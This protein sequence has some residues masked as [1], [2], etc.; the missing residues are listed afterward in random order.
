[1]GEHI[2][3]TDAFTTS[4]SAGS[5]LN[6][7]VRL[8]SGRARQLIRLH[9]IRHYL[10][11]QPVNQ[12]ED[13]T[14]E[15]VSVFQAGPEEPGSPTVAP[16]MRVISMFDNFT[17][18]QASYRNRSQIVDVFRTVFSEDFGDNTGILH[19]PFSF[20]YSEEYDLLLPALHIMMGLFSSDA[21]AAMEIF[22]RVEYEWEDASLAT[23][24]AAQFQW[25]QDPGDFDRENL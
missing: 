17:A 11:F 3:R 25:G 4:L 8:L 2:L 23:I 22:T 1:M 14:F 15:G 7:K 5:E 24:A 20:S 18:G 21:I 10:A 19:K 6:F 16:Q 12:G 9:R 13:W